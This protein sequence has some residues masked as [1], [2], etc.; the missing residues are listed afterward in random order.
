MKMN[1]FSEIRKDEK[2][3]PTLFVKGEPFLALAGEVHNSSASTSDYMDTHV[4]PM[5]EGLNLNT[6]IVP[7]YWE[8]TEP[9]EGEYHF[10][11]LDK[12]IL[13]A[14]EKG[15][16]LILLWFGLWKNGES[17]YVP[18]WMKQD[19]ETYFLAEKINGEKINTVSP[20]CREAVERDAEAFAELMRHLRE[21]DEKYSTVIAVQVENEV[22]LLGTECDYCE[23]S[24]RLFASEIPPEMEEEYRVSGN[25]KQ[26]FGVDAEEYFMA[27]YFASAVG[28]IAEEGKKEYPIPLFVNAWLRQHPWFPGTYPSGGPV[29]NVHRIW[30]RMAPSLSALAPDIYVPDTADVIDEYAYEGNPLIIPEIRKDAVTASY[31]LYAFTKRHALC[32]SPFGIEDL[33]LPP[34]A[35]DRPSKEVMQ[36]LNINP[37]VFETEGG[38]EYLSRVYDL[39]KNIQPLY[40]KYRGTDAME[41]YVKHSA[42]DLGICFR[43]KDYDLLIDYMPQMPAKPVSAGVIFQLAPNKFLLIG[44]MSRVTFRVK[45]GENKKVRIL[46]LEEGKVVNGEWHPGRRLNGDEQIVLAFGDLPSGLYIELHKA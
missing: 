42:T 3:I 43:F 16:H 18:G 8:Q 20:L 24:K 33:G 34:E 28:K 14:R 2:G 30:K 39:M 32:Y 12:I 4:W 45:P 46:K 9:V 13:T 21:L 7:V 25:W 41:S 22:G 37:A 6:L 19:Q 23:T 31:C 5:I 26:A 27:Y 1:R 36:A 40:L 38:K 44:M 29:R 35:V 15:I 11:I 10:E 17:M